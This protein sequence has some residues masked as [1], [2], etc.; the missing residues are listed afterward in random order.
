MSRFFGWLEQLGPAEAVRTTPY[1]YAAL[2][3]VHLLGLVVLVGSAVAFDLRLLGLGL[4][5]L[6]VTVAGRHLLPLAHVGFVFAALTGVLMFVSG[7]MSI[8]ASGAAPFKLAL[9]VVAHW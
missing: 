5:V 1:L 3:C 7:A 2:E 8:A 6:P 9:L 4:R